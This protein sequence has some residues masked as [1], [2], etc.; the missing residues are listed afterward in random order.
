M[1]FKPGDPKPPNSGVKKGQ[2]QRRTLLRIEDFLLDKKIHPVQKILDLLPQLEPADQ[3]KTW[4]QLIKYVEPELKPVEVI[5]NVTPTDE[6]QTIESATTEE[7]LALEAES[8]NENKRP[9]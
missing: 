7:L 8:T 2:K 1:A 5:L 9:T 3:V 4:L 6:Q